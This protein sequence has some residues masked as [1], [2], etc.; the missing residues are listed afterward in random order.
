ML[1]CWREGPRQPGIS[2]AAD[3]RQRPPQ[4][5]KRTA[6]TR[7]AARDAPVLSRMAVSC[8]TRHTDGPSA[9]VHVNASEHHRA[10]PA[11]PHITT[12]SRPGGPSPIGLRTATRNAWSAFQNRAERRIGRGERRGHPISV[13]ATECALMVR[14][15]PDGREGRGPA[16]DHRSTGYEP[17]AVEHHRHDPPAEVRRGAAPRRGR[18]SRGSR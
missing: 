10:H 13:A 9:P 7:P 8:R 18:A 16:S 4:G 1:L 11:R 14:P 3:S 6:G 12:A 15:S 5:T 2:A 17:F